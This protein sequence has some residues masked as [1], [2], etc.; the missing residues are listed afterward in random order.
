MIL[1]GAFYILTLDRFTFWG[2]I[3]ILPFVGQMVESM[4]HGNLR[5]W[6]VAHFGNLFATGVPIVLGLAML[7]MVYFTATLT[8]YRKF[9]PE[10]IDMTPIVEF[11]AKDNHDR[12]RYLTL[13]FG[14]QMAWLS[15]QT[16]ALNVEGNYHSARR[17][18][19]MTSTPVE[20][21]DGAKYTAIPGLGSL[22]QFLT[23]PQKYELKYVFVKDAFYEPLLFFAG[24][25]RL[26]RLDNDVI[27]WERAD[28]PPLPAEI[29]QTVYPAWQRLMWGTLPVGSIFVVA[30]VFLSTEVIFPLI[31]RWR[32]RRRERRQLAASAVTDEVTDEATTAPPPADRPLRR[33][34]GWIQRF[35]WVRGWIIDEPDQLPN[36]PSEEW[37]LWKLI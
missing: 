33:W 26:G 21:L 13:G 4:I 20:R 14:D 10:P 12:W 25:N 7:L 31:R 32:T 34:W 18:P 1:R 37:M 28:V 8:Q 19:E 24:W 22:Q 23:N 3:M 2:S 30:T 29:P 35:K 11:L 17:L 9:Q 15:A 27:V 16:T 5:R 36:R 6:M